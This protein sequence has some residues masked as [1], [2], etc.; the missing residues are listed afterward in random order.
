[1]AILYTV[2]NINLNTVELVAKAIRES[3]P[4]VT[5]NKV[6]IFDSKESEKLQNTQIEIYRKYFGDVTREGILLK[7]DG[8]IDSTKLFEVFS[9]GEEK[10]VDLSN[11]QKSTSSLLY[12][13]ASLCQIERIYYLMLKTAPK[14]TMISGQDYNYIKMRKVDCVN[15]LAKISHFD[16]IYYNNELQQLFSDSERLQQGPLKKIYDGLMSGIKEFF[17]GTDY[18]SV[19][20]NV[21]IGNETIINSFL[22]FLQTDEECRQYCQANGITVEKQRDPVG[23]LTYFSKQYVKNGKNKDLL[24]LTTVPGLMSSLRE[25]RNISAHYSENDF[26]LTEDQGRIVI[27]LSIE[28]IK[29][30]HTNAKFWEFVKRRKW[31]A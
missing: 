15:K 25:Y 7:D 26:E 12:L 6:V 20:A 5:I 16:L 18:R 21:T 3:E 17:S 2:G 23:I 22:A 13:A 8:S 27:N 29:R 1:M 30:I 31:S 11:G 9:N 19:V 14:E 28:V 24:A 4:D 10:I